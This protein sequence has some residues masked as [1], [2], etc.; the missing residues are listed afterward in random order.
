MPRRCQERVRIDSTYTNILKAYEIISYLD[1]GRRLPP[2]SVNP[3]TP[4]PVERPPITFTPVGP[5]DLYTWSQVRPGP[6][7]TVPALTLSFVELRRDNAISTP[8]VDENPGF[9][10]CPPPLTAKGV[11]HA[12][13][14]FNYVKAKTRSAGAIEAGAG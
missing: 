10:E 9:V 5:R 7:S 4:T 1:H 11:L 14:T 13:R 8:E 3:E 2:P 12:P 6:T